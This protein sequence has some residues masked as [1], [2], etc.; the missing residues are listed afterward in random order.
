[1]LTK[2][3]RLKNVYAHKTKVDTIAVTL[4]FLFS[5]GVT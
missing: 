1:M 3:L 4:Y 5:G 2:L